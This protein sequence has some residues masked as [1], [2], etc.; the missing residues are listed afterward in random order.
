[1][2]K[3]G[4]QA[5]PFRHAFW[6]VSH[7]TFAILALA[8]VTLRLAGAFTAEPLV[9]HVPAS[10]GRLLALNPF[11]TRRYFDAGRTAVPMVAPE[12]FLREKSPE[13]FRVLCLGESSTAGFPFECQVPFPR[14][15]RQMPRDSGAT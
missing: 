1:M 15:L 4:H 10:Q 13:T 8:E 14:Q 7:H 6:F 2:Y 5:A 11:V 3:N 9:I 12:V